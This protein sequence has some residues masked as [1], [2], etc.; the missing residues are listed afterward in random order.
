MA[1]PFGVEWRGEG[2]PIVPSLSSRN[3][4][5]LIYRQQ[6]GRGREGDGPGWGKE[7]EEEDN[8]R[9]IYGMGK[10]GEGIIGVSI[11]TGID[12]QAVNVVF[13]IQFK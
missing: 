1:I 2:T 8:R 9:E 11:S 12:I 6:A 5:P 3:E 10:F 4:W 7:E 13:C